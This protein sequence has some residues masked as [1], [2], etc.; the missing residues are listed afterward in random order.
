MSHLCCLAGSGQLGVDA[1]G[2]VAT[3]CCPAIARRRKAFANNSVVHFDGTI[4]PSSAGAIKCVRRR[5][6]AAIAHY[7]M[8][9][10]LKVSV[11]GVLQ[12]SRADPTDPE[13]DGNYDHHGAKRTEY[14][15]ARVATD[16]EHGDGKYV[17]VRLSHLT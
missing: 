9:A 15:E 4:S 12:R 10:V 6:A 1:T 17:A 13:R 16:C 11:L 3:R 8:A 7:H 5:N 2:G 14:P